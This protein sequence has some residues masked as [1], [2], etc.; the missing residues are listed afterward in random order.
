M[1][2]EIIPNLDRL[3]KIRPLYDELNKNFA[4]VPLERHL[5]ID[6]QICST[7]D[8]GSIERMPVQGHPKARMVKDCHLSIISRR[9]RGSYNLS[10]FLLLVCSHRN[11]SI[12][13]DCFK[14]TS[15]E[16][17]VRISPD[18]MFASRSRL[19]HVSE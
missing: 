13:D 11:T 18:L 10:A 12:K 6:E 17:A 1:I 16:R 7:K 19:A 5:S 4:K 14:K 9:T 15:R 3:H 2:R 8:T